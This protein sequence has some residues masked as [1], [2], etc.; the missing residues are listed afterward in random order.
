[1]SE[2]DPQPPSQTLR[3]QEDKLFAANAILAMLRMGVCPSGFEREDL[4][5]F[6]YRL[7]EERAALAAQEASP[8]PDLDVAQEIAIRGALRPPNINGHFSRRSKKAQPDLAREWSLSDVRQFL[9]WLSAEID[10]LHPVE[11]P[12]LNDALNRY[13]TACR[14]E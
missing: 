9:G 7:L 2:T 1:M 5:Q 8:Q 12:R 10:E 4:Q 6:A 14:Q 13:L 11:I 3:E